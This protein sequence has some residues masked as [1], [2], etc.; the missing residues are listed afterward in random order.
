MISEKLGLTRIRNKLMFLVLSTIVLSIVLISVFFNYNMQNQLKTDFIEST[1]AE[2]KQADNAINVFFQGVKQNC[3]FLAQNSLL[4]K[5]DQTITSYVD[6]TGDQTIM[7]P[8]KNGGI[9]QSIYELF[10]N[11]A[12]THPEASYIYMGTKDG[13]YVQWPEQQVNDNYDP[14]ERPFYTNAL[15]GNGKVLMTDAYYWGDVSLITLSRVIT[16]ASGEVIGAQALD[17]SLETLTEMIN[18]IKIGKTGYVILSE[19]NGTVLANPKNQEMNFKNFQELKIDGLG[20]ITKIEDGVFDVEVN[21]QDCLANVYTSPQLGWRYT[22]IMEKDELMAIARQ[23]QWVTLLVVIF[24]LAG[25]SLVALVFSNRMSKP[26]TVLVDQMNNAGSGDLTGKIPSQFLKQKD[27]IGI[28]A[29]AYQQMVDGLRSLIIHIQE[30]AVNLA[31]AAQQM[32]ASTQQIASGSQEQ[33]SQV[34]VITHN[35]EEVSGEDVALAEQAKEAAKAAQEASNTADKGGAAVNNVVNG[36]REITDNMIRLNENSKKIGEIISVIDDIADQTNL[37][38]LNAAIEAARAGQHGRGFAVVADE[39]RKLA[40]R[41]GKATKEISQL[42]NTI[43]EDMVKAVN[44]VRKGDQMTEEAGVSFNMIIQLVN[45]SADLI[46]GISAKVEEQASKQKDLVTVTENMA[47]VTEETA[48]GIEEIAASAE[49]MASM[50]EKMQNL[51]RG[52]KIN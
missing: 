8:S 34:Q 18:N 6:K 26:L 19:A 43:Q 31:A 29:N 42:I 52:F 44:A 49:E 38:A 21:G 11:Y 46:N 12:Q 33:A 4:L 47:A 9:E 13:G 15:K 32:S 45:R 50:S 7:T 3:D 27:E 23:I 16:D 20:D 35:I 36:M 37:L 17:V 51:V 30:S 25:V 48:A 24:V 1:S 39:V 2:I 40:E 41:S 22:A 28:L 14:R 10:D 5:A